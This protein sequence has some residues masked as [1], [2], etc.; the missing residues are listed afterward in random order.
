MSQR[1]EYPSFDRAPSGSI[2][3]NTDS[4]KLEL[5]NGEA[6]WEIDATSPFQNTG[7]TRALTF[8]GMTP[9]YKNNIEFI[10]IDAAGNGTDFGDLI[11]TVRSGSSA[12]DRTRA[13]MLG[14][15]T[16]GTPAGDVDIEKVTIASKGDAVD[17]GGDLLTGVRGAEAVND[18]TRAVVVSGEHSAQDNIMQ[19]ITIQ[20]SGNA[21]DFGDVITTSS[22]V[23]KMSSPT[24]GVFC[25]DLS[26]SV[27]EY[28]TISTLGNSSDFGDTT[29]ARRNS[30]ATSNSTRGIIFGGNTPSPAA[31]FK[32]MDFITLA[33]TGNAQDFGDLS[34]EIGQGSAAASQ[35]RAVMIGGVQLPSPTAFSNTI[36]YVQF[37]TLGNAADFGDPNLS[38]RLGTSTSNGHGGLG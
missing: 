22:S 26:T 24:R 4:A 36:E 6:W 38:Q 12:A 30:S 25:M 9:T 35:T 16:P 7:G 11:S 1:N 17:F 34:D 3:F 37:A 27:I 32:S 20:S 28:I 15:S 2:R 14:G 8:G 29:V 10:N 19:Y 18:R 5:Y 33:S 13:V 21:V 23:K 31:D